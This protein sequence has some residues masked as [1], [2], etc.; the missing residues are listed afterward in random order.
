M[1]EASA[2]SNIALIKYM[3]KVDSQSNIPSNASLS[4]TL[5]KLRTTV[6][7]EKIKN[8]ADQW[9][10]LT[11]NDFYNLQ[12]SEKGV[13]K[14]LN[15]FA[16]L[17]KEFAIDGYYQV[18][19][20]NNFPSDAGLASSASSFAALTEAT[21]LLKK[22][23]HAD[24]TKSKTE[25]A[26]LSRMGSGSSCR[27]FFSPW[28]TWDDRGAR[29]AHI[30]IKNLIH[31]AFIYETSAKKVSSSEAHQRVVMSPLFKEDENGISRI[32]RAE[33]RLKNLLLAFSENNWRLAFEICWQE[34]WDMHELFHTCDP[35]F[36]YL[37]D[38]VCHVL[39]QMKEKWD[40][41]GRGPLITLDAGP[42]VHCLFREEDAD[43]VGAWEKEFAPGSKKS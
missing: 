16:R 13:Q 20:A 11:G 38:E 24:F 18:K 41:E 40:R 1:I 42:N 7:L 32:D 37:T 14:F 10:P 39:K 36:T 31:R 9:S 8:V 26:A 5:E 21:Y 6:T 25:L 27:S 43:L 22:S 2:P 12:L 30:P 23:T 19:S 17:K 3:G 35:S 29:E 28:S 4:F 15:H 34:F 33:I